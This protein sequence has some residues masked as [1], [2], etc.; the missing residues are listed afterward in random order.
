M[1]AGIPGAGI[2]GLFYILSALWMP[3]C[4]GWALLHGQ[5]TA[6]RRALVARQ[7][8]L[9]IGIVIS[10]GGA[11]WLIETA[12]AQW[13]LM[14]NAQELPRILTYSALLIGLG[15]LTTVGL[16]VHA[17]RVF[18]A[19]TPPNTTALAYEEWKTRDRRPR[20]GHLL[21]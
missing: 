20:P 4:E 3:F 17:V 13:P 9:A 7:L 21:T 14:Q 10:M 5:S 18:V 16:S 8:A 11:A 6:P 2:G 1:T 19:K 12:L 15:T